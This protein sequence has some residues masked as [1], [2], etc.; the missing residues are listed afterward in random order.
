[1]SYFVKLFIK[2]GAQVN[3]T[4]KFG[5]TSLHYAMKRISVENGHFKMVKFLIENGADVNLT[6]ES[7]W[8]PLH[9]AV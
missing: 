3:E 2:S 5:N 1:M 6:G 7:G 4:S 8:T 9:F